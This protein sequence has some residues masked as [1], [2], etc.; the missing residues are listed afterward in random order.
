MPAALGFRGA[1]YGEFVQRVRAHRPS[2]LLSVLSRISSAQAEESLSGR[3]WRKKPA[4]GLYPWIIAAIARESIAY[5]NEYRTAPVTDRALSRL[6]DT[7]M[8]VRDPF[9]TGSSGGGLID[10][11]VR[12]AYEQFPWNQPLFNELSHTVAMLDRDLSPLDLEVVTSNSWRELLGADVIDLAGASF[13]F[14]VST[15]KNS[16]KFDLAWLDQPNFGLVTAELPK[17]RIVELWRLFSRPFI[18]LRAEAQA[19]RNPNEELRRLDWNPLQA[20]PYVGM[21]DGVWLAPQAMYVQRRASLSTIYHLGMTR[22]GERFT[23]DLGVILETYVGEQCRLMHP[24]ALLHDIEYESG[25]RAVDYV[26]V[27]DRCVLLIEVKSARVAVPSRRGLDPFLADVTADVGKAL[28]QIAKTEGLIKA[29]HSALANVPEDLPRR[30]VVVTLEPHHLINSSSIRIGLPDP[31]IT[32]I[33]MSL[34]EFEEAVEEHAA[35][36]ADLWLDLTN[37]VGRSEAVGEVLQAHR[38]A[39]TKTRPRNAILQSAWERL[40][41][42]E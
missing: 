33:V 26:L 14:G 2:E 17:D 31:G 23:R 7:Y 10:W 22:W 38:K 19:Q 9:F 35:R 34:G 5:G 40:P 11:A 4:F 41:F 32:T 39:W 15:W 12:T 27:L 37:A 36:P 13:L 16:G 30:G 8:E 20:A 25:Q 6:S 24:S 1:R 21:P 29:R 42:R 18:D 28:R 3:D